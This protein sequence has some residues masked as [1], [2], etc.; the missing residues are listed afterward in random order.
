MPRR[1]FKANAS[2]SAQPFTFLSESDFKDLSFAL[3]RVNEKIETAQ[4]NSEESQVKRR[5]DEEEKFHFDPKYEYKWWERSE[6]FI[7]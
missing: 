5:K 7:T 6:Y 2:A 1:N 3:R 4:F